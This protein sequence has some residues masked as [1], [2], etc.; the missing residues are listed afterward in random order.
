MIP[1]ILQNVPE[2][3]TDWESRDDS[4]TW[5]YA[6]CPECGGERFR[7][8]FT[9]TYETSAQCVQCNWMEIIHDG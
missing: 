8:I 3:K 2:Y 7:V 9:D 1:R 5:E 4:S 6:V